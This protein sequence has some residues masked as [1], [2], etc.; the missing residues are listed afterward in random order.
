VHR[1]IRAVLLAE[2]AARGSAPCPICREPMTIAMLLHLHHSDPAAKLAGLP[3][4]QLAHARCNVR[5]G[6]RLGASITNGRT[7]TGGA[8]VTPLKPP[9]RHSRVW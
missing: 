6:A 2:L 7:A 4:D 1:K 9:V 3:G 8:T 5:D